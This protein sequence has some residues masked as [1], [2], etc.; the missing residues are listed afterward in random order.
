MTSFAGRVARMQDTVFRAL[1]EDAYWNEAETPVRV[2]VTDKDDVAPFGGGQVI[3][4]VQV[5]KVRRSDVEAPAIGDQARL[6][7]GRATYRV[8]AD[9]TRDRKGSW[10]CPVEEVPE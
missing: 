3:M 1:G 6:A 7:D 4:S 10:V 5:L 2:R 9:P 8:F